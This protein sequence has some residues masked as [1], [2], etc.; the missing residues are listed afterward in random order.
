MS[1][2]FPSSVLATGVGERGPAAGECI[3]PQHYRGPRE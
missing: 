3:G 1:A 2:P